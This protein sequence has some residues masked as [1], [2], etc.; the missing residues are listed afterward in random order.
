MHTNANTSVAPQPPVSQAW[1]GKL[2]PANSPVLVPPLHAFSAANSASSG[3][4]SSAAQVVQKPQS[5]Y[6]SW[7]PSQP[8]QSSSSERTSVGSAATVDVGM[9]CTETLEEYVWHSSALYLPLCAHA[10]N[11]T[12]VALPGMGGTAWSFPT[13]LFETMR[14]AGCTVLAVTYGPI[15][16]SIPAIA[17]GVWRT[18]HAA[19]VAG[20]FSVGNI[21]LMGYSMGGFVAQAMLAAPVPAELLLPSRGNVA[22][23]VGEAT[24]AAAH[25]MQTQS[26]PLRSPV[27]GVVMLASA[28]PEI[29]LDVARHMM[30]AVSKDKDVIAG[31]V[32]HASCASFSSTASSLSE[33]DREGY[34]VRRT[35]GPGVGI[36]KGV[37]KGPAWMIN[38]PETRSAPSGAPD[39]GWASS[40]TMTTTFVGVPAPVFARPTPAASLH[41]VLPF[42]GDAA[43]FLLEPEACKAVGRAASSMRQFALISDE[44]WSQEMYAIMHFALSDGAL[45]CGH[46][47][48]FRRDASVCAQHVRAAQPSI[49]VLILHGDAD[50]V[51]PWTASQTL[52]R[53]LSAYGR[54]TVQRLRGHS[55]GFVLYDAD[56]CGDRVTAWMKKSGL[57]SYHS[58]ASPAT[59]VPAVAPC[60]RGSDDTGRL[61]SASPFLA[62]A[63][64]IVGHDGRE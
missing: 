61:R 7:S 13:A 24:S 28:A 53:V 1:E 17:A 20:G 55:H 49:P 19:A 8:L 38:V 41:M 16:S 36:G 56:A 26:M 10:N 14:R 50:R 18:V 25:C 23:V 35:H 44:Q 43:A 47:S 4:F 39:L 64:T 57:L 2:R 3:L 54:V 5:F 6:S 58:P 29:T 42:E 33:S 45:P 34:A 63:V 21:V 48:D 60:A 11:V 40:G 31:G 32:K 9:H 30:R 12:V 22:A 52:R 37:G 15:T 51:I 59:R 62:T 46:A 27:I